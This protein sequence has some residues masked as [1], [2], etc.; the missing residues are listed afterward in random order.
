[1]L[2]AASAVFATLLMVYITGHGKKL[3]LASGHVDLTSQQA[4]KRRATRDT[5][6]V[7][8]HWWLRPQRQDQHG[9]GERLEPAGP[10]ATRARG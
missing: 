5:Q 9:P 2:G 10:C 4:G 3:L 1:M 6:L 8:H 7:G